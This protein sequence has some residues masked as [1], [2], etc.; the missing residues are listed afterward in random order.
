MILTM[1]CILGV[2]FASFPRSW[3][4]TET[5]GTSVMDVGVGCIIFSSGLVSSVQFRTG[6]S[7]PFKAS[8]RS[9]LSMLI[10]GLLRMAMVKFFGY[11]EHVSEYGIHWNFFM[12]LA[13][14]PILS[15]L[16]SRLVAIRKFI[17]VS[18]LIS[19]L[20]EIALKFVPLEPFILDGIRTNL[21]TMNKEGIFSLFGCLSLFMLSCGVGTIIQNTKEAKVKNRFKLLLLKLLGLLIVN[22]IIYFGVKRIGLVPS[23]RLMNFP[24]ILWTSAVSLT[25]ITLLFIMDMCFPNVQNQSVLMTSVND[26]QLLIFLLA[27]LG[28]G[29]VNMLFQ[30][31]LVSR[32][33]SFAIITCYSLVL[34]LTA[35]WLKKLSLRFRLK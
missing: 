23:R 2:D 29:L 9:S 18:L 1:L 35:F 31:L 26:N 12:T 10:M 15:N 6:S 21:F 3:A 13:V 11:Q 25:H 7:P 33:V 24:F 20:Y 14:L 27:N 30:T 4:K 34:C 32:P 5:W 22:W 17:S 28:T 19:F 16:L 8:V